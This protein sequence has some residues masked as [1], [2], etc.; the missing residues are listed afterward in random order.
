MVV[1][2]IRDEPVFPPFSVCSQCG[3]SDSNFHSCKKQDEKRT[4]AAKLK[5]NT[6]TQNHMFDMVPMYWGCQGELSHI[7]EFD[8]ILPEICVGWMGFLPKM[9]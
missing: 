3:V 5:S 6:P 4:C 8:S 1:I 7:V 9:F 2:G